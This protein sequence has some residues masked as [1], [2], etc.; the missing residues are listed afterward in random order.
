[1]LNGTCMRECVCLNAHALSEV[2]VKDTLCVSV[3]LMMPLHAI[4]LASSADVPT[5]RTKTVVG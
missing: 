1:M 5:P 2:D 3:F 4:K